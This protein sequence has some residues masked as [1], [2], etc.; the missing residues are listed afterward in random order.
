MGRMSW[1]RYCHK[2]NVSLWQSRKQLLCQCCGNRPQRSVWINR[3]RTVSPVFAGLRPDCAGI[4]R[5]GPPGKGLL[6]FALTLG[7]MRDAGAARKVMTLGGAYLHNCYYFC[8]NPFAQVLGERQ[9]QRN[10]CV[11]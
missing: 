9:P 11:D 10:R 8:D 1:L 4:Q 5:S 7:P 3:D 2:M 6:A